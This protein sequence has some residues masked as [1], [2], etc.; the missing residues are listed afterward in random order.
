ESMSPTIQLS[1]PPRVARTKPV[2]LCKPIEGPSGLAN[3]YI[4]LTDRSPCKPTARQDFQRSPP[5]K[6]QCYLRTC[7]EPEGR[8]LLSSAKQGGAARLPACVQAAPQPDAIVARFRRGNNRSALRIRG[9]S[10]RR[11][12]HRSSPARP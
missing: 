8:Q 1:P 5:V 9:W 7:P 10:R 12:A 6:Q 11:P 4:W 3:I 2:S